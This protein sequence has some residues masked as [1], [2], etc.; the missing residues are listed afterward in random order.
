MDDVFGFGDTEVGAG[1]DAHYEDA[2]G[3]LEERFGR[4][5]QRVFYSR[6]LEVAHEKAWFHWV[7][8]RAARTLVERGVV[9]TE[10]RAL[11]TGQEIHLMWHRSYR[12]P[13]R[14]GEAVVRLV[15]EYSDPSVGEALGLHGELLVL[16]G[17]AS[18]QFVMVAR[19]AQAYGD[20]RWTATA[21]NLD[22]IFERDGLPYG[23][24]V[25]NTLPYMPH[26]ELEVKLALCR[27]IGV[28]PVFVARM[29]P[30]SWI[31]EIID[32]GGFALILGWQLYPP[33]HRELARRVRVGL[34]LPVD[35]PRALEA[36]TIQRF[37]SWHEGRLQ[38]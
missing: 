35:S 32:A 36:G 18:R 16:E 31:N 25:K 1:G 7:T 27:A 24:E 6:Q 17:F 30:K 19:H 8:N 13:R 20:R 11:R 33:S 15:S 12:Y 2:L 4:E 3:G 28:T 29:L 5:R 9:R 14:E 38:W 21:H 23:V 26:A 10:V 22:F 34:G 37:V